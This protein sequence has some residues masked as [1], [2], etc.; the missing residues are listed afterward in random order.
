MWYFQSPGL[1]IRFE[2][3]GRKKVEM[4]KLKLQTNQ[5]PCKYQ[6]TSPLALIA[7]VTQK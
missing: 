6:V 2:C 1:K 3:G 7:T 4:K 5:K